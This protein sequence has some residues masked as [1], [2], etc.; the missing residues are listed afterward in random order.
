MADYLSLPELAERLGIDRS[1]IRKYIER[2]H[3][4]LGIE[5]VRRATAD[6]H[7]Q[8]ANCLSAIDAETL[9]RHYESRKER[10]VSRLAQ[11]GISHGRGYFYFYSSCRRLFQSESSSD[12]PTVWPEDLPSIVHPHLRHDY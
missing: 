11:S 7:G 9:L 6:S 3:A 12:T 4:K 10:P 8:L 1:A 2:N 5:I